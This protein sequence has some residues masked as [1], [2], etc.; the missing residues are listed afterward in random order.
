MPHKLRLELLH[1][2]RFTFWRRITGNKGLPNNAK[3]QDWLLVLNAADIPFQICRVGRREHIYVPPLYENLAL[4]ELEAFHRENFGP[5][6]TGSRWQLHG[7]WWLAPLF[8]CPLVIL[9]FFGQSGQL[10]GL[11]AKAGLIKLGSLDAIRIYFHGEWQ[12]FIT[13]LSLHGD[14]AHL[15]GNIFFG[16]VFLCLLAR[17]CGVG[18]AWLLTVLGGMAGN[19]VSVGLHDFSYNSIGFSTA[20]FACAGSLGAMIICRQSNPLLAPFAA[21]L[22]LLAMLGTEGAHTDY[23]AHLCGTGV[24][25]LLGFIFGLGQRW[26]CPMPPQWLCAC[27]AAAIMTAGWLMALRTPH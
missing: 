1:P 16:S 11:P 26:H 2:R 24:G 6:R 19:A 27:L 22:A 18:R 25:F 5:R 4:N 17:V 13:A 8:L 20:L 3:G 23:V 7:G 12:R 14:A 15:A 9:H 10:P 21:V